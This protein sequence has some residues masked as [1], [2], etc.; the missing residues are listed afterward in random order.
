MARRWTQAFALGKDPWDPTHRFETSWLLP[1]YVL[2]AFRA[3]FALYALVAELFIIGWY[4]GHAA[5]G[6]C[7]QARDEFSYFTVL[8]YWG[9]GFY[10]LV[11]ALHTLTYARTGTPLLARLPRPLQ[12]LHSLYYTTV[13]VYP[14]VVTI[15]YWAR[16]YSGAWFPTAF[17]AWSNLSQ[18][19]LNSLLAL[20]ELLVPRTNPPPAI[21]ALWLVLLLALYLALAY[22]TRATKG[23]Y[24]YSFLD[25]ATSGRGAVAGYVFGIAAGC[26][27][28]FL[29]A[30]G[31]IAL[32]RWLTEEKMRLRGRFAS[33]DPAT[34]RLL[35]APRDLEMFGK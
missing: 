7:A 8:T 6:G 2:F 12:A 21:H 35:D 30:R 10:F 19:A 11:S 18:H 1:P 27:V 14:F 5:L 4:C 13:V 28:V 32:R 15:V 25:P 16:L 26:L 34:E 31:A 22:L 33:H 23:F 20:F 24:V 9:L 3:L 29:F 17:L